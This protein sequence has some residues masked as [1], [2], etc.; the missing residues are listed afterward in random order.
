VVVCS[1]LA[2]LIAK[3]RLFPV[4]GDGVVYALVPHHHFDDAL[5]VTIVGLQFTMLDMD[6]SGLWSA[7]KNKGMW[8]TA[9][10]ACRHY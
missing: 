8:V 3:L 5:G 9:V 10:C 4:R 2:S 7:G 6:R 1:R